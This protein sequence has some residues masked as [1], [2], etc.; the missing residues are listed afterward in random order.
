MV[1]PGFCLV[2]SVYKALHE[3][4][5]AHGADQT[6][7]PDATSFHSSTNHHVAVSTLATLVTSNKDV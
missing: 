7:H 6:I 1:L 3:W 5:A 2:D 4:V